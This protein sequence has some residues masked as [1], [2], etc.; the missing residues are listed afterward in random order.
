[1]VEDTTVTW[2]VSWGVLE[3]EYHHPQM[4]VAKSHIDLQWLG[5]QTP[6]TML[7][8]NVEYTPLRPSFHEI[9]GL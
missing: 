1:M 9:E 5:D 4:R 3:G 8:S 2:Q 6:V 7:Y